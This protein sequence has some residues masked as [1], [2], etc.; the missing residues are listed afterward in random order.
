M[1][2]TQ[3][4]RTVNTKFWRDKKIKGLDPISKLLFLYLFTNDHTHVAGLYYL[5]TPVIP[6]ES[7]LSTK[8]IGKAMKVLAK[9]DLAF[10]DEESE[11][12]LV[13]N[14]ME[15]QSNGGPKIKTAIDKQLQV[16]AD[17]PLIQIFMDRY[18]EVVIPY[19]KGTRTHT[20]PIPTPN[21]LNSKIM[22]IPKLVDL[23]HEHCPSM[24]VCQGVKGK[25]EQF[26][27]A[28]L[29]EH[30]EEQFWID[31]FK[32]VE[33]SDFLC[34]RTPDGGLKAS[35]FTWIMR[36]TNFISI[37]EGKYD[38]RGQKFKDPNLMSYNEMMNVISTTGATT[39]DFIANHSQG[40]MEPLWER[41]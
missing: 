26:A 3:L 6:H 13:L 29:G 10:H 15:Y 31:F 28:R 20:T 18:D 17:S 36:P 2:D 12:V 27:K 9:H 22:T 14:M 37:L 33:A 21:T 41:K 35:D 8:E 1:E 19:L 16:M 24:S 11:S 40:G 5:P 4:I 23:Y 38:N 34:Q 39:D 25:R 30:Q 7:G 32:K